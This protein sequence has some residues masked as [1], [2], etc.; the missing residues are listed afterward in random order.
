MSKGHLAHPVRYVVDW[1]I[2]LSESL[3]CLCRARGG[4]QL[5]WWVSRLGDGVAWYALMLFLPGLYGQSGLASSLNM[6]AVGVVN[7]VL[8]KA[9]KRAAGRPR[10]CVA[11]DGIVPG[12]AP[13]DQYSFPSGHTMHAVAFSVVA[14]G[15]HPELAWCLVPFAALVALS[16]VVL[17]LHYPTDVV[18][19]ALIGGLTASFLP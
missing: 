11:C 4:N 8:Y 18:A 5:F 10:P 2:A 9:I 6:A 3:N 14:I 12:T 1:D 13:L 16:R 7:V 15:H 17:G 19:G